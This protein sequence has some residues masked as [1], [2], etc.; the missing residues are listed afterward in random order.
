LGC[1]LSVDAGTLVDFSRG[2]LPQQP[3]LVGWSS[4]SPRAGFAWQVPGLDRLS[5]RGAYFRLYS[6][7]AGRYLDFGNPNSLGGTEYQWMDRNSDGRFQSGEEGTPLMRFGGPY[8]SISPALRRPYADEFNVGAEFRLARRT[9][10]SIHLFRRDD[11]QRLAAINTGVPPEA[12][13][14]V[15]IADPGPD[16]LAGTFDDGQLVVYEQDPATFGQDQYL[17]TNPA[18]LRILYTGLV[19]EAG[20]EWRG[21]MLRASFMATKAFGPTNPGDAVFEND[22][23]VVGTLFSDPNTM[24][25]AAGRTFTD[26]GYVGKIRATYRFPEALGRIELA[27]AA[28][29]LDGLVFAR[30]SLVTGLAQGPF[31]VATTVRGSPEGGNRSEYLINWNLRVFREFRLRM[32]RILPAIDILNVINSGNKIQEDNF[33]GPAFN[34]RLPIAIQ[35]SRSIRFQIRYEF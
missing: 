7:L 12:F 6:P 20:A 26:R 30:H 28:D 24:V 3:D 22:P 33:S 2:S 34:L 14:P 16:G 23:G 15:A 13:T 9:F 27:S 11:K 21:L 25:H 31:L 1:G 29:Y 18:G 19:A 8:S 35:E 17:L 4:V 10:A 5:I 32:G